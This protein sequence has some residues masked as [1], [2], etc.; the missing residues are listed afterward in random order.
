MEFVVE[1]EDEILKVCWWAAEREA[2]V[3]FPG[4]GFDPV[5]YL[6]LTMQAVVAGNRWGDGMALLGNLQCML[7]GVR[8]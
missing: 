5:W 2:I 3:G 6:R 4:G 1:L 7:Q 8:Y